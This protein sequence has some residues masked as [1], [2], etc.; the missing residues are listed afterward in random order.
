MYS[1]KIFSHFSPECEKIFKDIEK[2][3]F[4]NFFQNFKYL[5]TLIRNSE[6]KIKIIIIYKQNL[7]LAILPLEIKKYFTFKV[8]Q[9]I[10]TGYADY[11][12]PILLKNFNIILEK[13][14]FIEIWNQIL[15][16]IG[17]FDLIFLNNQLSKIEKTLNPFVNYLSKL[18][19]SKVYLIELPD[20]F[21]AYLNEIKEKDKKYHYEIHRTM[22]K[23]KKLNEISSVNFIVQDSFTNNI[24]FKEIIELKKKYLSR[25][26]LKNDFSQKF[27]DLYEELIKEKNTRFVSMSLKIQDKIISNC[28]GFI[29]NETFYY[30]IPTILSSEFNR[31]KPGK[32]LILEII[33]WCIQNDIKKFDFGLGNEKYKKHFSNKQ[34]SMYKHLSYYTL[35]GLIFYVGAIVFLKIKRLW[36]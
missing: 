22:I 3:S 19:L 10:G 15:K 1:Y 24:N 2:N 26:K 18:S 13:K 32:I 16:D 6:N 21:D 8:L 5:K 35:K 11:C 7:A 28:F 9:W 31:F 17:N 29:Y 20:S 4:L 33:K 30:Y 34:V 23:N 27:V 36:L 25:Q 12:N 14:N